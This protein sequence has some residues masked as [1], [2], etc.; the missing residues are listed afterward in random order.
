[1]IYKSVITPVASEDIRYNAQWYGKKQKE[2]GKRFTKIIRDK[3]NFACKNPYMYAVRY[4]GIR[5]IYFIT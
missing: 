5:A 3:I 4:K 2:L 1:M